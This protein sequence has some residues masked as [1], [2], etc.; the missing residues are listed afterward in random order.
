M[1]SLYA[2][3]AG[4]PLRHR[5]FRP[6]DS[7]SDEWNKIYELIKIHVENCGT[8]ALIGNR[9]CGKTQMGACLIGYC[10]TKLE[11]TAKYRK[12][13]EI[14]YRIREGMKTEGDSERAAIEEFLKPYFLVI[15]AYEVRADSE[16]ENRTLD[17]IID[18]RYDNM[19]STLLI[20]NE[21]KEKFAS[22]LGPSIC[23][24]MKEVG[25]IIELNGK[26]FR[27]LSLTPQISSGTGPNRQ[28]NTKDIQSIE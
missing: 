15:D 13:M 17:Y 16:F 24:R 18:K 7:K 5:V 22:V 2:E 23:D 27:G 28:D 12:A 14:F 20:S 9:G 1:S 6:S 3:E 11:K 4:I 26:S 8:V 19:K 25:G 10:Y 21:T